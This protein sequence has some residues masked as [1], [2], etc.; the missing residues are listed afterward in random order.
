MTDQH[1]LPPGWEWR[2]RYALRVVT[3]YQRSDDHREST[4]LS[5]WEDWEK[6]SGLTREQHEAHLLAV[7]FVEKVV[8]RIGCVDGRLPREFYHRGKAILAALGEVRGGE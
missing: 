6:L 4:A 7:E 2:G 5:V 3:G 8:E 1:K